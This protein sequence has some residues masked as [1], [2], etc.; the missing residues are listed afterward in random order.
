ML[1]HEP[2]RVPPSANAPAGAANMLLADLLASLV[3]IGRSMQE[4]FD[5]RRFLDQLSDRLQRR[6]PHDRLVVD[7]LDENGRTFSVLAE[8]AAPELLLHT[9]H[10]TTAFDPGTRYVVA[11]WVLRTVFAGEAMRVDDFTADPRFAELNPYERKL[12]DTGLRSGLLVP[13]ESGG[14]VIG[15]LVATTRNSHAYTDEHL[16]IFRQVADLIAPFIEKLLPSGSGDGGRL[17]AGGPLTRWGS[18]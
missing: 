18:A 8:H 13:L 2:D 4:E 3:A 9:D 15:A 16:A 10:Y 17:R 6:V 5:P 7:Y 12:V 11:E 14:R 1:D